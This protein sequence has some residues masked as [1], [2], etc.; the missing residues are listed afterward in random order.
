MIMPVLPATFVVF[1][2]ENRLTKVTPANKDSWDIW[3]FDLHYV[4]WVFF[5]NV[6]KP[7]IQELCDRAIEIY[8]LTAET[9]I[10]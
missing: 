10:Q 4:G 3:R 2:N 7:T 8:F 9:R 5:D 1:C 6:G